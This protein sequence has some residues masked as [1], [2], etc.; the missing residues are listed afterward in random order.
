MKANGNLPDIKTFLVSK[1][2]V[3]S[4]DEEKGTC[5]IC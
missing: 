5:T 2:L 4:E 3:L 1:D